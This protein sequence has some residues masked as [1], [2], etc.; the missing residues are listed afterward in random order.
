[1]PD[2]PIAATMES[3][4]E[5]I[6]KGEERA[7]ERGYAVGR[8][9]AIEEFKKFIFQ[10]EGATAKKT[11]EMPIPTNAKRP[12]RAGS[13]LDNVLQ[14]IH[15]KPGL[16]G[17]DIA[18]QLSPNVNERTVRTALHRLKVRGLIEPRE[19][20]WWPKDISQKEIEFQEIEDQPAL[21]G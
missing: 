8:I 9:E 12:P 2:D 15:S 19:G 7:Y 4:T 14:L 13:D 18:K 6:R 11:L 16:R 10:R 3:V 1:M 17:V 21:T 5:A 20:F